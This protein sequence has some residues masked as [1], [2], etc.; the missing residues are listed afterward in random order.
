M[1]SLC[2][3][4]IEDIAPHHLSAVYESIYYATG[5]LGMGVGFIITSNC[6][7]FHTDFN[8]PNNHLPEWLQ[9]NH[10]NWIGAWWLPFIIFGFIALILAIVIFLFPKKIVEKQETNEPSKTTKREP[11][12]G[13]QINNSEL[14]NLKNNKTI[15]STLDSDGKFQ[16]ENS[17]MNTLEVT[18]SLLSMNTVG[19]YESEADMKQNGS[20]NS[21]NG[22]FVE[23]FKKTASLFTN[24]VYVF[25]LIASTI[26]GLLQNS[27]LA[28]ASLFLEYQYRLSSGKL[29]KLI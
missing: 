23:L 6:L 24:P 19:F 25:V 4:Y 21:L 5:A 9:S 28:F 3:S 26:E 2:F 22:G 7:A 29:L 27:F 14:L 11:N 1:T 15:E 13:D 8:K 17:L 12:Q 16:K 18:G 10:P 20:T